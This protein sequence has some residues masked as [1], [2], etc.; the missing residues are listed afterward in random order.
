MVKEKNESNEKT[1]YQKLN[2]RKRVQILFK[3]ES[4]TQQQYKDEVDINNIIKKYQVTGELPEGKQGFYADVSNIPDYQTAVQVVKHAEETFNSLPSTIRAVFM[5]N[6]GT[7]IKWLENP[8]NK[9]KAIEMGLIEGDTSKI[10]PQSPE[11]NIKE[12]TTETQVEE[13]K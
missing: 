8:E 10:Q 5:N 11:K 6:P 9:E 2:K 1:E 4:L 13:K 12:K 3:D 7:M